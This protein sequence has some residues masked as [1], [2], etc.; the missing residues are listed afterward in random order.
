MDRAGFYTLS[1]QLPRLE[2]FVE[3][4]V[5]GHEHFAGFRADEGADDARLFELIDDARGA[6]VADGELA[7]LT[8]PHAARLV[9]AEPPKPEN[10][11]STEPLTTA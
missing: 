3:F 2:E 1:P 4:Q 10:R 11:E 7:P 6:G 5:V 8:L 9:L